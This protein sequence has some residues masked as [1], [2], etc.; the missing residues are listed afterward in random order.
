MVSK[1]EIG[2]QDMVDAFRSMSSEG[3]RFADLMEQQSQ[4]LAGQWSNLQDNLASIGESIGL[5]VI[6]AIKELVDKVAT[7]I[8]ENT[9]KLK[10]AGSEIFTVIKTVSDSAIAVIG[11]IRDNV[12]TL[13]ANVG[14]GAN[15]IADQIA[16]TMSDADRVTAE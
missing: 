14:K 16:G 15:W 2:A 10:R 7:W 11:V 9:D 6:P 12:N 5:E 3:G 1:G 8:D 13:M 4:T